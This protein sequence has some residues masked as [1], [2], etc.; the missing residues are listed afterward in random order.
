MKPTKEAYTNLDK[1]YDHF[2]KILFSDSLPTCIITLQ[3]KKGARGYFWGDTWGMRGEDGATQR[4]DE[5][6]LNPDTFTCRS[7]QEILSTLVHEMCH[8]QQHHRGKPSRNGYHNKEWANMMQ[9][10]GLIASTTGEEGGNRTGQRM[11]HYIEQGGLF[12]KACNTLFKKGIAVRWQS[13]TGGN[14]ELIA[15]KKRATKTKY[16]CPVCNLNAWGKNGLHIKCGN[17]DEILDPE[18][19]K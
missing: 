18:T 2:N 11:T 16:T 9:A 6:A 7:D 12:E 10:V 5:I 14:K 3:R 13:L 4:T 19:N 8:L 17:C 15:K 1:A